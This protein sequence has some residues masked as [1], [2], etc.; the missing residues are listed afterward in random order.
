[1]LERFR[2]WWKFTN[3]TAEQAKK[4]PK[5]LITQ[6]TRSLPDLR[7]HGRNRRPFLHRDK[8]QFII[9]GLGRFGT[10]LAKSLVE[11]GH[12]VLTVD[13]D[14]QRVQAIASELPNVVNI[15]AT[16]IDALREIGIDHF[17][18]GVVCIG[19]DFE[20]NLLATVLL[21]KLGVPRVIAK[22]RTRTQ[23]D[24]LIQVGADEVILPEHEAGVRLARRL[25][26]I[27]LVD[28]LELNPNIGI[29]EVIAPEHLQG[30]TL[31]EAD[32]RQKHGLNI[33]AIWRNEEVLVSPSADTR[34][35]T[36]DK[37]L[38]FGEVA[39]AKRMCD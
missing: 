27:R 20:S 31:A 17:D 21:C 12:T 28:F 5:E 37:L 26:S 22:A 30:K 13:S 29:I 25:S 19:T 23:R 10:S 8:R 38:V 24:I 32:L 4:R 14:Y 39:D 1:M 7:S 6:D 2:Q 11:Q 36:N 15:D 34:I 16:N 3:H 33:L 9:I 18:I 35:L